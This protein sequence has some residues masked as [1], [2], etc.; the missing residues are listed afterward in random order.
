MTHEVIFLDTRETEKFLDKEIYNSTCNNWLNEPFMF[1]FMKEPLKN[2]GYILELRSFNNIDKNKS[3]FIDAPILPMNWHRLANNSDKNLFDCFPKEIL[4]ECISGN[5]YIIFNNQNETDTLV[6]YNWFYKLYNRNSVVPMN[7]IIFLSPSKQAEKIYVEWADNLNIPKKD[8]FKVIYGNHIDLR[9][10]DYDINYWTSPYNIDKTK[11][12]INLNRV[13]RTQRIYLVSAL[14]ALNLIDQG[15][16]SLWFDG[17]K[18]QLFSEVTSRKD[19]FYQSPSGKSL[20]DLI[21]QGVE[22]IADKVPMFLDHTDSK[23]NPAGFASTERKL[24]HESYFNLTSTTFFFKWQEPSPGWNEKEWK[25]ILAKQPFILF[26]RTGALSAMKDFGIVTFGKY[27]DESYDF[28]E[29]DYDRF[30]AIL[31]EIQRLSKLSKNDLDKI[32]ESCKHITEYNFE[33]TKNKRWENI[34]YTGGLKEI[35][36]FIP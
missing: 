9:F 32:I 21:Y 29:N 16:V 20:F 8:R 15:N 28:I 27:I 24:Y 18:D 17:P 31:N 35:L 3:W 11:L 7:K 1:E 6:T 23:M 10:N 36:S 4:D 14:S 2:H 30:W 33:Y 26:G 19:L 12:F 5:C 34:F 13:P 22:Q 25:P